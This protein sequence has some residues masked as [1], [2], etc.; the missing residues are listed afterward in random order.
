MARPSPSP[1]PFFFFLP[2]PPSF[3]LIPPLSLSFSCFHRNPKELCPDAMDRSRRSL[4]PTTCEL[5][6]PQAASDLEGITAV[7]PFSRPPRP[8]PAFDSP[9]SPLLCFRCVEQQQSRQRTPPLPRP[10]LELPSVGHWRLPRC[11]SSPRPLLLRPRE[12]EHAPLPLTVTH[13][14]SA[15]L[16]RS[17]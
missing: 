2:S 6:K 17:A 15:R 8:S 12:D 11:S 9:P 4:V 5:S 1:A 13:R 3:A 14:L 16:V 10:R 7:A